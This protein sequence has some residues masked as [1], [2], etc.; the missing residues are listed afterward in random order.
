MNY[1]K[2]WDECDPPPVLTIKQQRAALRRMQ[3]DM[4]KRDGKI[5]TDPPNAEERK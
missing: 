1:V 2:T 3:R 4:D 5:H